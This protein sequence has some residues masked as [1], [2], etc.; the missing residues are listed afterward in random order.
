MTLRRTMLIVEGF[1]VLPVSH[2]VCREPLNRH[3]LFQN[4]KVPSTPRIQ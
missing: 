1:M 4:G 3:L 2:I